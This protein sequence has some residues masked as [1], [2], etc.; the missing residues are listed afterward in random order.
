MSSKFCFTIK[1]WIFLTICSYIL[2]NGDACYAQELAAN[3][4][5]NKL[6]SLNS[7]LPPV[8]L[9]ASVLTMFKGLAIC[10]LILM[11]GVWLLKKLKSPLINPQSR[12]LKVLE[13]L[14]LGAR[15]SLVLVEV[16]QKQV[17]VG[18]GTDSINLISDFVEADSVDLNL[19][20][21]T[22]GSESDKS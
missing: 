8:D 16:N 10:I 19:K 4:D 17:L 11:L 22:T 18:V 12:R 20:E 3:P 9:G 15:S 2:L 6:N 14:P 5:L 1:F 21:L 7:S 13:R